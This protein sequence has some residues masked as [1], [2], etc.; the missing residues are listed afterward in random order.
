MTVQQ[1]QRHGT[2]FPTEKNSKRIK[3][4][5]KKLVHAGSHSKKYQFLREFE[6]DLGVDDL[7]PLGAK[8]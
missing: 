2:R 6:W 4:P 3:E 1:L 7:L 5:V 8:E